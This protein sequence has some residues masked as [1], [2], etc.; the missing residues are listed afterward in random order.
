VT[1][2]KYPKLCFFFVD[3]NKSGA[4]GQ[5]Y[6]FEQPKQQLSVIDGMTHNEMTGD[7]SVVGGLTLEVLAQ[8]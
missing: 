1:V 3:A 4:G 8:R 7:Q 2:K 5:T 6:R